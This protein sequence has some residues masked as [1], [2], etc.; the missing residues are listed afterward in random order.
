[1]WHCPSQQMPERRCSGEKV[2]EVRHVR[3]TA[4]SDQSRR[5]ENVDPCRPEFPPLLAALQ[6]FFDNST[7]RLA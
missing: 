6:Q 5:F 4:V 1:M 2:M 3:G 7:P